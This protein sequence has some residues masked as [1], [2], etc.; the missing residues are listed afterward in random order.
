[1][2]CVND[3]PIR[4]DVASRPLDSNKSEGFR[5]KRKFI[6]YM[7]IKF[8]FYFLAGF[9]S[10]NGPRQPSGNNNN[11]NKQSDGGFRQSGRNVNQ[12][13][14]SQIV[15]GHYENGYNDGKRILYFKSMIMSFKRKQ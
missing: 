6:I 2:Q 1:M 15:D 10:R 8:I 7:K 13:G 11:N 5:N 4:I 14:G 9:Q 3:Q 12:H